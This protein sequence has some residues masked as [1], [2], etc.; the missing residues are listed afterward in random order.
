MNASHIS[1]ARLLLSSLLQ[2]DAR[3]ARLRLSEAR[4][5]GPVIGLDDGGEFVPLLRLDTPSAAGDVMSL[6]VN[7]HGRWQPTHERGTPA[8]L[9]DLLAG[10]LQHLWTI[11]VMAAEYDPSSSA[12]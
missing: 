2:R 6:S 10:P 5:R 11:A 7:L 8:Q 3:A 1:F 12:Q 4:T 9:A